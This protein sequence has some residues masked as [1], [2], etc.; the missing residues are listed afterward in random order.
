MNRKAADLGMPRTRFEDPTG[1]GGGNV[2]NAGELARLVLAAEAYPAIREFS[3]SR[4]HRVT[5]LDGR[6]L[7]FRNSNGLVSNDAWSIGLSKTG[8][9]AAAGRCLVMQ[10]VVAARPVIIVLLDSWGKYT[11]QGDANRIRK[12]MEA[13]L[14]SAAGAI[15]ALRV[16]GS[17]DATGPSDVETLPG[18]AGDH[19]RPGQPNPIKAPN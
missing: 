15:G 9:I 12:W 7:E 16:P 11:R 5:L 10:A 8:Y 2:S 14:P 1:L 13:T 4:S 3:T 19:L 6:V 17:A 18:A